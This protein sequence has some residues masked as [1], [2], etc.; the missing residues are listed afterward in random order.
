L[1]LPP[2]G[3]L[4]SHGKEDQQ[5]RHGHVV[6]LVALWFLVPRA[7]W[8]ATARPPEVLS[9]RHQVLER[10]AYEKLAEQWEAYVR[11]H[12][13]DARALVEWGDALRYSGRGKEAEAC[14]RRAFAADSTDPVVVAAFVGPAVI[15]LPEGPR[16]ELA[17]RRLER[18]VAA[19]PDVPDPYYFLWIAYLRRGDSAEARACLR[20]LVE[21]GDIPRPLLEYGANML[22]GA[23]RDAIVFTNGDNDTYPPLAY[24]AVTS[25][26]PDVVIVNLSLLKTPWYLE[27]VRAWGVPVARPV[28]AEGIGD[29]SA[30][31]QRLIWEAVRAQSGERPVYY[32][33][34]VPDARKAIPAK[35]VGEGLLE[36]LLPEPGE[37]GAPA[38]RD[39]DATRLLLDGVYSLEAFLDP[40]V[41]W[42]RESA[43]ASLGLNYVALLVDVATALGERRDACPGPDGYLARAVRILLAIG[44]R[45]GAEAVMEA[46]SEVARD[47]ALLERVRAQMGSAPK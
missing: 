36:R 38:P 23:D 18:A 28:S 45:E 11:E 6:A 27:R 9:Y 12:P 20:R 2:A 17:R 1:N 46:W 7:A 32:A 10:E 41:D 24:Q 40:L 39:I 37:P 16:L 5:M 14:Y 22:R 8:G 29:P 3:A 43:V 21:L 25:D 33:V 31:A 19:S 47:E 30:R 4:G 15:T 34:T 42:E 35:R 26:R 13:G 44:Q